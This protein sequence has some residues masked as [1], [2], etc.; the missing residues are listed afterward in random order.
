MQ[1]KLLTIIN[2]NNNTE[3]T[4]TKHK[5][6]DLRD[7]FNIQLINEVNQ[8]MKNTLKYAI[9]YKNLYLLDANDLLLVNSNIKIK[10]NFKYE[11][12][13]IKNKKEKGAFKIPA[14]FIKYTKSLKL[15]IKVCKKFKNILEA[16]TYYIIESDLV[17]KVVEKGFNYY[18]KN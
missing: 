15:E 7:T 3:H 4:T 17:R 18:L 6:V 1:D 14:I 2:F 12:I 10:F 8:N 16:E 5:P 9:K 11:E 13:V